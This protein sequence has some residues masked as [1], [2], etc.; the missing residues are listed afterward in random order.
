MRVCYVR[1]IVPT[2]IVLSLLSPGRNLSTS[3]Y[4]N[5]RNLSF[6]RFCRGLCHAILHLA[7]VFGALLQVKQ[8][9]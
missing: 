6:G 3:E 9:A 5:S 1:Y 2:V 7:K 4:D 8:C